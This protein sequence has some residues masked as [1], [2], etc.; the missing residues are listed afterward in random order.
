MTRNDMFADVDR[1]PPGL[2]NVRAAIGSSNI[3]SAAP[4]QAS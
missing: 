1:A 2:S 3:A 4:A